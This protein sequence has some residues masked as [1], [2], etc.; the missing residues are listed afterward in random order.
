[1]LR[2]TKDENHPE[3]SDIRSMTITE[4][5]ERLNELNLANYIQLFKENQVDGMILANLKTDDL[6]QELG[7]KK[8]EAVRLK[9][10]VESGH[11]P[12]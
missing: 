7:M 4:I 9:T 3:E 12:K 5:A 2:G 1:M 6:I 10:F 8:L 11:I